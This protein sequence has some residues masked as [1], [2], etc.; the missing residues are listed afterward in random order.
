MTQS[1]DSTPSLED[2][3]FGTDSERDDRGPRITWQPAAL[4]GCRDVG[5]GVA[6]G[7][8]FFLVDVVMMWAPL[9]RGAGSSTLPQTITLILLAFG[10]GGLLAFRVRGSL[11]P[12]GFGMMAG[13]AF[14]TLVSA[15]YLT[16]VS[17]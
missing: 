5:L 1:G 11:R 14:C 4:P 9:V 13:W 2:E 3:L 6:G 16:G 8:T 10:L 7:A 17:P 12:Y 15:G